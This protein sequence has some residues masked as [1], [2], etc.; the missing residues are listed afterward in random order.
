MGVGGV[1]AGWSLW[2]QVRPAPVAAWLQ[3]IGGSLSLRSASGPV[4]LEDYRGRWL[5]LYFGYTHCPDICP[6][7]LATMAQVMNE[8]QKRRIPIAGLFVSL[9]P[10]RDTPDLLRR[11][12][13]FFHP[14]M[15]GATAE[16][17]HL[18]RIAARWRVSYRV[19]DVGEDEDY[20]VEHS[21]FVYLVD[22]WGRVVELF[23]E[24]T[25]TQAFLRRMYVARHALPV[26]RR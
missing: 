3:Q 19:P 16:A 20:A 15:V 13:R 8:A 6:T 4:S 23:D 11:Y 7:A 18:R 17:E 12:A 10:R 2:L 26:G 21:T 25:P 14:D 9:D 5:L 1:A 22:P 24:H